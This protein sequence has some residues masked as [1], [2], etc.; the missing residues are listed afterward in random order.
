MLDEML[1]FFKQLI[2]VKK[3]AKFHFLTKDDPVLIISKAKI[4]GIG[5][6]HFIIEESSRED[7]PLKIKNWN[8]SIFF[9]LPS[10]SKIS[11]SPTKQGEL[12]G[13]GIPIICNRGIGDVDAIVEKYNSG[14]AI[15]LN[16]KF[17]IEAILNKTFDKTQIV[18]GA[19]DYFSLTKG[20]ENYTGIYQ[21]ILQQA[22]E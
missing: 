17:N 16:E 9:I 15:E 1:L 20:L 8:F 4:L 19:E 14:M 10:Y 18:K 12:M 3:N 6:E 7:L 13:L 5:K 11:S 21:E 22:G 2:Q